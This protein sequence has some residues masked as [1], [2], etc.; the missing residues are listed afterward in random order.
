G[1]IGDSAALPVPSADDKKATVS[2]M[3]SAYERVREIGERFPEVTFQSPGTGC[4][5]E[6][7]TVVPKNKITQLIADGKLVIL[8]PIKTAEKLAQKNLNRMKN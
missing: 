3:M 1:V 6:T 8:K 7:M 4:V 2:Y 5:L